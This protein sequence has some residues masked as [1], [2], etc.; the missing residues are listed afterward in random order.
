MIGILSVNHMIFLEVNKIKIKTIGVFFCFLLVTIFLPVANPATQ[1]NREKVSYQHLYLNGIFAENALLQYKDLQLESKT[2]QQ[3]QTLQQLPTYFSWKNVDGEDYTTPTKNQGPV[4]VCWAF[5]AIAALESTI[6]IEEGCS[7]LNPDLS[8]Q[9]LISCFPKI[10]EENVVRPFFWIQSTS[11]D[12]N[13]CN[14]VIPE[15]CFPYEEEYEVPCSRK[16]SDWQDQLIPI[17]NFSYWIPDK[18]PSKNDE[19]IKTKIMETGPVTALIEFLSLWDKWFDF[20]HSPDSVFPNIPSIHRLR[21]HWYALHVIVILGWQDNPL[22]PSGGYWICKNS[23]GTDWGYDGFFNLAY[24]SL[25]VGRV[26]YPIDDIYVPY[27]GTVD[28]D[29][30]SYDWPPVAKAGGPY[31]GIVGDNI[32]FDASESVDAEDDIVS[33]HWDFGDGN[34]STGI[35][36]THTYLSEGEYEVALTVTDGNNNMGTDTTVIEIGDVLQ[37]LERFRECFPLSSQSIKFLVF[38]QPFDFREVKI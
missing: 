31:G 8:E 2:I 3:K 26:I 21:G 13:D 20:L 11:A 18:T 7:K 4:G 6:E 25:G 23:W 19:I 36:S 38:N 15:A 37:F 32:T 30:D 28:Y 16:C 33:Y 9:Y 1:I 22:M 5:A 29:P 14:G 17:C 27:I 35:T 10:H 34:N 12:G 24:G